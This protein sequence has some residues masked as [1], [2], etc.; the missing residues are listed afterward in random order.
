[1][2][3]GWPAKPAPS[4]DMRR[5]QWQQAAR[6]LAACALAGV[7]GALLNIPEWYWSLITVIA[8][9]Q[10]DLSHTMSAGRDRV[11]ATV[12]GACTGLLM[13]LLRSRGLPEMPLFVAAMVPLALLV[14]ISPNLRLA[15]T[16]LIVVFLIP[17]G[18]DPYGR[19]LFRVIDILAGTL[20]SVADIGRA[21]S[22]PP[23]RYGVIRLALCCLLVVGSAHAQGTLRL[24]ASTGAGSI[25]P[26]INY[27]G[28]Y[29]QLFTV[30][31][32]GLV[33]FRRVPG[34]AGLDL[35]PDLADAVPQP[36]EEGRLYTFHLR[37]GL[38]FSDGAP[39]RASDAAASFRRIFRI[40]GPTAGS[41]YG[42]IVGA[43]IA[44]A[45]P[46]LPAAARRG[47][48]RR[49]RHPDHPPDAAR[50][51]LP[52]QAGPAARQRAARLRA[53]PGRGHR[54]A[55][56]HRPLPLRPLRPGDRR[57]AGAQSR[58][59]SPGTRRRSRPACPTRSNT[60]SAWRTRRR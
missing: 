26:Q 52:A 12:I 51:R 25:D 32:D 5:S 2:A 41:F 43:R 7:P 45:R 11:I 19:A 9:M 21:V 57:A 18:S 13:I 59:S 35:V 38:R 47:R 55:G 10:P 28:Q 22:P 49:D 20:A 6:L 23:R 29:W 3:D 37:P 31:Y 58:C 27:T 60:G 8:V 56:R 48:G 4:L 33:A 39:V 1:M 14:G 24:L 50:P 15:C 42:G 40:V 34:P 17:G 53:G 16:T 44:C 54:A 30:V 36:T 46:G